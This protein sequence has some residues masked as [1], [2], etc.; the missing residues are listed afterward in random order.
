MKTRTSRTLA[1]VLAAGCFA[2]FGVGA[3]DAAACGGEWAPEVEVDHRVQG[4]A[5]A[6]KVFDAGR[7]DRA[8]A[9]IIRMMPHVGTLKP[10]RSKL[11]ERAQRILAVAIA[12][13]EGGVAVANEVPDY[14]Q[15]S[16]IGRT[17]EQRQAN[18]TWSV[19]ALR[20]A[21]KLT[22]DD[23]AVQTDL[24]EAL[25]KVDGNRAEARQL[26][27]DLAKKD[28]V[29]TPEGYAVLAKLRSEAGDAK[30]QKVALDR[31]AKMAK[32]SSVCGEA[33]VRAQS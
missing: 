27:E 29:A 17:H 22:H 31:C 16:W 5:R 6:E 7:V 14:A 23:P 19:Q 26:L 3:T 12:R 8:A 4:I 15:G 11:V 33:S 25:S 10:E 13:G 30:G 32:S 9:S 2:A 24:A 20:K 1:F 21:A 18:L 28:L